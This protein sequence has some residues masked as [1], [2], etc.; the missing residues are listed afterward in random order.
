[1]TSNFLKLNSAKTDLLLIGSPRFTPHFCVDN[2]KNLGIIFLPHI[3]SL[4]MSAFFH[5]RNITYCHFLT[6]VML[7]PWFM[8]SS[9]HG[10][11][12]AT[13]FSMAYPTHV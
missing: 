8:L 7:K 12:T 13:L 9:L 4:T 5:L 1:M 11:T 10:L 3:S 2:V 6:S